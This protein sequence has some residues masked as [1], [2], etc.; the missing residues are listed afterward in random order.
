KNDGGRYNP[1][2]NSWAPLPSAGTLEPRSEF[3]AVW[4]GSEMLVW[5]GTTEGGASLATGARYNPSANNWTPISMNG[6]PYPRNYPVAVW[7]G[8]EMIVWGGGDVSGG[9]FHGSRN[10]G[11]RYNPATDHWT[12]LPTNGAPPASTQPQAVWT[13]SEMIVWGGFDYDKRTPFNT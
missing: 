6:A 10:D 5:G 13:G 1:A 9:D 2:S 7:T 8:T 3:V 11:G 4:T 12:P